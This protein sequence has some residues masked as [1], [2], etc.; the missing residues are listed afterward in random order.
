MSSCQ[1]TCIRTTN[2]DLL[3][4]RDVAEKL[5]EFGII[6]FSESFII[7]AIFVWS[8]A[9]SMFAFHSSA[10][11]SAGSC[12]APSGSHALVRYFVLLKILPTVGFL[13]K[14]LFAFSIAPR[15]WLRGRHTLCHVQRVL[16]SPRAL[17]RHSRFHGLLKNEKPVPKIESGGQYYPPLPSATSEHQGLALK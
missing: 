8:L 1:V 11:S 16:Y 14:T 2:A 4:R 15:L 9:T 17:R 12:A 10:R 13:G 6:S 5:S 3:S 7:F